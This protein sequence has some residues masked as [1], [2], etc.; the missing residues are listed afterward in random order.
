MLTQ[1]LRGRTL[2][3]Q[4]S[5]LALTWATGCQVVS[6]LP[7]PGRIF[8]LRE[9]AY[10][11]EYRL[12][13]PSHYGESNDRRWP[14][15]VVCHGTKPFDTA[16]LQLKAWKGLAEREG[17][18]VVA[19][20]L[21]GTAGGIRR[22]P[23][24]QIRRQIEDEKAILSTVRAICA[25]RRVDETR[26]FLTCWSAGGYA[27]LFTGLRNPDVFRALSL[28][29]G[30]FDPEFVEP[31]IPFLDRYQQVQIVHGRLDPID[32]TQAC[33]DWLRGHQFEPVI[34]ERPGSHRRD[35]SVIFDFFSDVVR[36]HPW[37][38]VHVQD[39]PADDMRMRFR[40][41]A[42]FEPV[43]FRWDFGDEQGSTDPTPEHRYDKPGTYTVR[44]ALWASDKR[45]DIRRV[46]LQIPRIRIGV[47]PTPAPTASAPAQ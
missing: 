27:V 46:K 17:F 9:P 15:V 26:V 3:L 29:Q 8:T 21:I 41:K 31:C 32:N 6:N 37:I 47:T 4:L 16:R 36:K 5:L 30:N 11:R 7:T 1:G 12:Y 43:R 25:A 45:Y 24:D 34:L 39:D 23:A 2:Y 40:A 19:P 42:S 28:Y 22:D 18:L 20:E 14:L 33:I 10:G 44:V 38:R 13:V 35:P